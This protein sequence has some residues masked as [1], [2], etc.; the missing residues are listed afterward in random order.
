MSRQITPGEWRTIVERRGSLLVKCE[1][2]CDA[3]TIAT[4]H[5]TTPIDS[6]DRYGPI[7]PQA[8]VANAR[9]ISALPDL[10][11]V[12]EAIVLL[13][14]MSVLPASMTSIAEDARKALI[15]AGIL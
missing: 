2:V 12:A 3:A 4:L 8:A 5:A 10:L 15:K 11:D 1:V 14:G 9:A 7:M 6:P 13:W